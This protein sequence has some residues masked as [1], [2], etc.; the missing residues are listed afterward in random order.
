MRDD[1]LN[2]NYHNRKN[3]AG[4]LAIFIFGFAMTGYAISERLVATDENFQRTIS[5]S[6]NEPELSGNT[7]TEFDPAPRD[8]GAEYN[9]KLYR[10]LSDGSAKGTD[11]Q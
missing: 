2:K 5:N 10:S 4:I 6:G 8:L 9:L 3:T 1:I 7:D 11:L